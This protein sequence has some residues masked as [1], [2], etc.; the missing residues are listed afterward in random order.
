M[1][2]VR[3][4]NKDRLLE[5]K[6]EARGVRPK[7]R[8]ERLRPRPRSRPEFRGQG[9]DRGQ[10]TMQ[11]YHVQKTTNRLICSLSICVL[12]VYVRSHTVI[13]SSSCFISSLQPR[14]CEFPIPTAIQNILNVI[15]FWSNLTPHRPWPW[16][17]S[18]R[19]RG[20][21][22]D[23]GQGQ[24]RGQANWDQGRGQQNWPRDRP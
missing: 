23:R 21:I 5:A 19:G 1:S 3:D 11:K 22:D 14:S 20:Q 16:P 8:L 15:L 7:P 18:T 13:L 4:V 6:A 10:N 2:T 12:F 9:R 17:H 24:D